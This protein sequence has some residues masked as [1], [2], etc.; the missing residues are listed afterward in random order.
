[1]E[2]RDFEVRTADGRLLRAQ[3][4]GPE[5]GALVLFHH[6]TPGPREIYA[7][8]LRECAARGLRHVCYSRPGYHGS[9]RHAGRTIADCAADTAAVADALGAERFHNV[10]YSGGGPHALACAALLGERVLSTTTFGA[11]GP[12]YGEGLDWMA[13]AGEENLEEFAA[14][15]AGDV[16]LEVF[17]RES[18]AEM[19]RIETGEDVVGALGDLLADADRACLRGELLDFEVANWAEIGRDDVWGWLDDDKA[20]CERWGFEFSQVSGKVVIWHGADDRMV[21]LV[22][23]EWLAGQLPAA[24]LRLEPGEGHISVLEKRFGTALDELLAAQ[25]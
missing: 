22:N 6:G 20:T 24:E 13:G 5:D 17:L 8:Q 25:S 18:H 11:V 1:M 23:A 9:A 12:P 3:V 15:E 14:M 7:G 19:A 2:R 21:P 4:A 10:G 16:A